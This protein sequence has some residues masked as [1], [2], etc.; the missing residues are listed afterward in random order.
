MD[1]EDLTG[2]WADALK[3]REIENAVRLKGEEVK[4]NV[5][6]VEAPKVPKAPNPAP[7]N[8]APVIP[9]IPVIPEVPSASEQA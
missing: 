8:E 1:S 4:F 7:A 5:S 3:H 2:V 9:V 6:E